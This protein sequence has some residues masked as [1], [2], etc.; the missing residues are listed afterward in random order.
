MLMLKTVLGLTALAA[1][2]LSDA[3]QDL[4]T[5]LAANKDLSKFYDL[6]KVS[7]LLPPPACSD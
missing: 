7:L 6:I 3:P 2:V 4:G 1:G 5:V